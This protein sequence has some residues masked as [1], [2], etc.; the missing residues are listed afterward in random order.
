VS[1]TQD[2][3]SNQLEVVQTEPDW[4]AIQASEHFQAMRS[5]LK[6][7]ILPVTIGFLAWYAL[8][9]LL[10]AYARDF[11]ATQVI[12]NINVAIVMGLLQ[13]ASTFAIA[14]LYERHSSATL[15]PIAA[16]VRDEVEAG[17]W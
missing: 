11:M 5:S 2:T 1:T 17:Q 15:D 14:A 13:F 4:T 8:F 9:V 12:G 16:R 7:F 10:T 6:H 3:D